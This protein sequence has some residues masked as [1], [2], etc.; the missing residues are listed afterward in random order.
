MGALH[1]HEIAPTVLAQL[2][3]MEQPKLALVDVLLKDAFKRCPDHATATTRSRVFTRARAEVFAGLDERIR[4][5]AIATAACNKERRTNTPFVLRSDSYKHSHPFQYPKG[6]TKIVS[7]I[8]SRGGLW[9]ELVFFGFQI[10]LDN[11]LVPGVTREDIERGA[12]FILKHMGLFHKDLWLRLIEKHGGKLPLKIRAVPEGTVVPTLNVLV[13]IENTDPEF[14]WL[15]SWAETMI[16]RAV[17][18]PTTVATLSRSVRTTLVEVWEKTSDA[19]IETLDFKLHDF[20]GRGVSSGESAEIGGAA[21]LVNFKGSDTLEGVWAAHVH[22]DEEMPAFSIPAAEHATITPWLREGEVDAFRN[23]IEK[24]GGPGAMV[25][26][27]SDSYDL[28][29][30]VREYWGDRLKELVLESGT[31]LIVRPDSG[32][33]PEIV[34]KT[35]EIL[36]ACFGARTNS[37]GYKVLHDQVRVIQGDGCSPEMIRKILEA[38]VEAGYAIDNIAF[39][40]GGKLLQGVGRDDAKFAQKACFAIIDDKSV[41]VFKDPATDTGKRSKSGYP[42]LYC[43]DGQWVT[44]T[45]DDIETAERYSGMSQLV[46]VFED[47]E[48]PLRWIFSQVRLRAK[49]SPTK[50]IMPLSA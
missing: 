44:A 27:V 3:A 7:Y 19:P 15:T 33:P 35:L 16:L 48:M 22:Y 38:M 21:H 24:F 47:G 40:M 25:A 14:Y 6:T 26:V 46:T 31:I 37:K 2:L 29:K 42:D 41:R 23:M 45:Y 18:Y 8:E 32:Y 28:I 10:F 43:K 30:A 5:N 50:Q 11:Y 36:E 17:W 39:G 34:V 49:V 13:V 4:W 12:P 20:G 1:L 9:D